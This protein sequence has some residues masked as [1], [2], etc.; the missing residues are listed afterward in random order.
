M[1]NQKSELAVTKKK[2]EEKDL[3]MTNIPFY[4]GVH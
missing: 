1:F 2:G 4:V 3:I